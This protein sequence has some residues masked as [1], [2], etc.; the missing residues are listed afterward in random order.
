MTDDELRSALLV[1]G[2]T[3]SV[4]EGEAA[5]NYRLNLGGGTVVRITV[6]GGSPRLRWSATTIRQ[7][8]FSSVVSGH[9]DTNFFDVLTKKIGELQ[10]VQHTKPEV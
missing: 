5:D 2:F 7:G 1:F 9:S 4:F 10:D 8:H 6:L 3:C